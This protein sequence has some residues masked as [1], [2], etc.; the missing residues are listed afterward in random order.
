MKAVFDEYDKDKNG[1]IET[2]ELLEIVQQIDPDTTQ[3]N[4]EAFLSSNN[5]GNKLSFEDFKKLENMQSANP[6]K[7]YQQVFDRVRQ[8]YALGDIATETISKEQF[9]KFALNDMKM[10]FLKAEEIDRL[11]D[12]ADANN[13][14]QI[15]LEEFVDF[16]QNLMND[17][18]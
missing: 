4:I 2:H 10:N 16:C 6:T 18:Q 12:A 7:Q 5:L 17:T 14:H 8:N 15:T 9:Q 1:F 13:D 3:E 11:F